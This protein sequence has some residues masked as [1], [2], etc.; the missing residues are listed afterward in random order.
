MKTNSLLASKTGPLMVNI[1]PIPSFPNVPTG[2]NNK[3][4]NERFSTTGSHSGNSSMN[5]LTKRPI[6]L[7]IVP[8]P[9]VELRLENKCVLSSYA[10]AVQET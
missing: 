7:Q 10:I 9:L 5:L 6:Y 2:H 8:C 3:L 1:F 4:H